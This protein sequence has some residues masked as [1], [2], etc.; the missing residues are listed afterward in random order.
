M[1]IGLV[2][3]V[4]PA[5]ELMQQAR[6]VADEIALNDPLAVRLTKRAINLSIETA[7]LKQALTDAFEIDLQIESTETPESAQFNRILES[8]GPKA[9]LEWRAA[10]LPRGDGN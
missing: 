7:G 6:A 9:A 5:D 10:Q 4:V 2:N 1:S 8:E 3:K